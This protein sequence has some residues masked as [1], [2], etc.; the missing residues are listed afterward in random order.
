MLSRPQCV[1]ILWSGCQFLVII[2]IDYGPFFNQHHAIIWIN[3]MSYIDHW[4]MSFVV[5]I[6]LRTRQ[7]YC[8]F[9]DVFKCI[10]L[11]ENK[12]I[13]MKFSLKFVPKGTIDNIP[14]LVQIMAWHQPGH[15]PLSE[16]MMVSLLLLYAPLSLNE[17][18]KYNLIFFIFQPIK[19]RDSRT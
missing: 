5:C 4:Q 8:N 15:K 14:A 11:S 2:G 19:M 6:A 9:S 13:Q 12:W 3:G 1:K 17:L 10:S 18:N 7:N 16:P